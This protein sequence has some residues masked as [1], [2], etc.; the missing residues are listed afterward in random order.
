MYVDRPRPVYVFPLCKHL[1]LFHTRNEQRIFLV[2]CQEGAKSFHHISV[3]ESAQ[4]E[5][6]PLTS[7]WMEC[8]W[9]W[10]EELLLGKIKDEAIQRNQFGEEIKW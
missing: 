1:F 5:N 9:F 3:I 8:L 10:S 6:E 7:T 4:N 2:F